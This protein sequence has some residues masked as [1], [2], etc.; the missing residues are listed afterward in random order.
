MAT[1]NDTATHPTLRN[2]SGLEGLL[3]NMMQVPI[4]HG[5]TGLHRLA[6]PELEAVE[7]HAEGLI[8]G[9][10]QAIDA[11]GEL[12]ALAQQSGEL[13]DASAVNASW[14]VA[15]L[16]RQVK[17]LRL[18]AGDARFTRTAKGRAMYADP[19]DTAAN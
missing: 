7:C 16:T 4:G 8:D 1:P 15:E 12:L 3:R 9:H 10:L 18:L 19:G 2:G 6:D 5:Y 13:E 17:H 11:L 14:A